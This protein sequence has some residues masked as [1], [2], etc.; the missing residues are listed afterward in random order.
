M[1]IN[2]VDDDSMI[3]KSEN[4]NTRWQWSSVRG[5]TRSKIAP[6]NITKNSKT[7]LQITEL[8]ENELENKR[9]MKRNLRN[10]RNKKLLNQSLK[11]PIADRIVREINFKE[12]CNSI[13]KYD[14]IV[15]QMRHADQLIFPADDC[16]PS[17]ENEMNSMPKTSING[18]EQEI[19]EN[20]RDEHFNEAILDENENQLLK[21]LNL[22]EARR[23]HREMQRLRV[24]ISHNE[25]KYRRIKRIKSKK[26]HRIQRKRKNADN[27]LNGISNVENTIQESDR[28]RALERASLKHTNLS[29]WSK[30]QK[31]HCQFVEQSRNAL[32]EQINFNRALMAKQTEFAL[33]PSEND[34][35][36]SNVELDESKT[37]PSNNYCPWSSYKK[38]HQPMENPK[39][40]RFEPN[41]ISKCNDFDSMEFGERTEKL[42]QIF[43]IEYEI[44]EQIMTQNENENKNQSGTEQQYLPGWSTKRWSGFGIKETNK[45]K[46]KAIKKQIIHQN[47]QDERICRAIFFQNEEKNST[48]TDKYKHYLTAKQS[49]RLLKPN[50]SNWNPVIIEKNL[51]EPP[52]IIRQGKLIE[53]M[54][55]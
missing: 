54:K 16:S 17:F 30:R 49:L 43:G 38:N 27:I 44:D 20:S 50:G 53:P 29:K 39:N 45:Y 25:A 48:I 55:F 6:Y 33:L 1:A 31:T 2:I 24:L 26:Y 28:L 14:E 37:I 11:K 19:T 12:L 51:N 41:A 13:E 52:V 21:S 4:D 3:L 40:I 7:K 5:E 32:N 22:N 15:N 36:D 9:F 35:N 42:H 8:F 18:I 46:L 47:E 10:L 23:L 34:D